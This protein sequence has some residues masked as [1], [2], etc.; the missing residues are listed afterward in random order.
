M[1]EAAEALTTEKSIRLFEKFG[2]YTK[3][4]LV[5]RQE[6]TYETYSKYINIEAK[7]MIDMASKQYIPAVIGFTKNLADTIVALNSIGADCAV[8][9]KLL[10]DVSG[11]LN[12]ATD[13]LNALS[14]VVARVEK[15][16]T[17]KE[18][19]FAFKDEV[20]PAMD[21]LRAPIDALE[22]MVDEKLWPVPNYDE[23]IFEV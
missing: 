13:A 9:K 12:E 7:T 10:S 1:V 14:E 20:K 4:E 22:M 5:A 11:K 21:S 16:P 6:I 17:E 23:L 18:K 19:A 3:A 15:L 8:Q 2:I